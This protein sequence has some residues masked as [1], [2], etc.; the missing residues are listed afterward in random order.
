MALGVAT[1]GA[2]ALPAVA[3]QDSAGAASGSVLAISEPVAG[4][5][6]SWGELF[7]VQGRMNAAAAAIAAAANSSA[8][9]GLGSFIAAPENRELRVYW[10]GNVPSNVEAVINQMRTKIPVKILPARFTQEQLLREAAILSRHRELVEVGPLPDASGL[11]VKTRRG[12]DL[13][14]QAQSAL[15]NAKVATVHTQDATTLV[16][17]VSRQDDQSPY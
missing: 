13:P 12:A 16:Q 4:G 15:D 11:Q 17:L 7:E 10:H 8:H 2:T 6:A 1:T 14:S 9:S 3:G 5:F